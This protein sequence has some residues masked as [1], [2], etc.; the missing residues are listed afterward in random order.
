MTSFIPKLGLS[1]TQNGDESSTDFE[2]DSRRNTRLF[3]IISSTNTFGGCDTSM[4]D[5]SF[6]HRNSTCSIFS[7][8]SDCFERQ[9][10][11]GEAKE[12]GKQ[13]NGVSLLHPDA[14]KYIKN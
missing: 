13:F 7:H 5:I 10:G 3:S 2:T 12:S 6:T 1:G 8:S 11:G 4:S 9:E 14:A